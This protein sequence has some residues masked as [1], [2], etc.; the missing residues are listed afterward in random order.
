MLEEPFTPAFFKSL[1]QLKIRTR[2]AILGSRQGTHRSRRRGHG[3]EFSDYK[4]Y[5]P[6]DD[7]RY[8]DWNIYGKT[9]R[10]YVREFSEEHDLNVLFLLDLSSSMAAPE[11]ENK[12][13]LARNIALSLSYVALADG[14][15]VSFSLLGQ[16]RTQKFTGARSFPHVLRAV[17][18]KKPGGSFDLLRETRA[19]LASQRIPGRIFFISDFFF[20]EETLYETLNLLRA[21]NFDISL[22]HLLSPSEIKLNITESTF[23]AH[24]IESDEEI[25]VSLDRSSAEEYARLL[26]FRISKL[27]AYC[28]QV[29]ISH[30]LISSEESLKSIVLSRFPQLGLLQ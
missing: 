5:T 25:E 21:R 17:Q 13:E 29:N 6:G 1:E 12:W 23:Y 16:S 3:L 15:T 2:R 24:D 4:L 18:E 26:A 10:F 14:D 11:G 28:K 9:D 27:E 22:I 7:F 20:E 19:A 8:I 30:T